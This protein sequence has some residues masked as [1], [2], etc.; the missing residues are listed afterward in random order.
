MSVPSSVE[1]PALV[2][3]RMVNEFAYCQRLFHLEWV[4][5]QFEANADTA[6]GEWRHRA[7]DRPA[8][9]VPLPDEGQI[10]KATSVMLGSERLG[11]IAVIDA[12]EA[13]D[14]TVVP[15]DTKKGRPPA[16]G[17][18][19]EPEM[20]Q[21][22]VQGLLLQEHGYTCTY[23]ELYFA[24]TRER[25]RIDFDEK[26][27][28][29]TNELVS[30][31]KV[32]AL[33]DDAPPPL[34]DSPK[35]PRCSLVGIC[36]PDETN[37]LS[38]RSVRPPR[39]LTP[40]DSAARP[41]YVTEQG[42]YVGVKQ[43]RLS[44]T[45]HREVIAEARLIDVSQLNIYGNAQVST[46]LLRE[47]FR[48]Q[49]PVLWFSYGGWFSGMAEGL[50][51]KNVELR[52]RQAG[53]MRQAGLPVARRMVEGKI[54]NC[55]TLLMRNSR[56]RD[57]RVIDSLKQLAADALV[58]PRL[59]SL[60]GTEGAAARLYFSQFSSMLRHDYGF[61]FDGRNRRPPKD[62]I[63]CLISYLYSL[64]VKDLTASV[65]GVGFDPYLGFYHRPRF[66]RPAL[67]LDLAEE[68]RPIVAD[69]LAVS[70]VN[71][72][73]IGL[74]DFTVRAGGVSLTDDGRRTVLKAYERRLDTEVTHPTF[75]YR[76][77]YRRVYEV[78]ARMLGAY[79]MRE[80]PDYVPFTTR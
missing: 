53:V 1:L 43:G 70:M 34:V 5:S 41:V 33:A 12:L 4:Q 80:V 74:G 10:R 31:L 2:P 8:G 62:P 27:V 35:C 69:S 66:G 32:V 36:L 50:P 23:G 55:R 3:A 51:G 17:P 63:N 75:G 68:F 14:G 52:R 73:E 65:Y 6:E 57:Q 77:T 79:L 72:G 47:C 48:R 61:D 15:V 24:E 13:E 16:H 29:R 18:A 22:C 76:V 60:L 38:E 37:V 20:V 26:L 44:V 40:R 42:A 58:A 11:L 56:D 28:A 49:V 19:W 64:V 78:Q 59:E 25:R 30:Q 9:A 67:A 46:Q 45:V 7:V 54:R 21:L 71:N 39:R